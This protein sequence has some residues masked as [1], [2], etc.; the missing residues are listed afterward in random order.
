MARPTPASGTSCL[1]RNFHTHCSAATCPL[2]PAKFEPGLNHTLAEHRARATETGC[3]T[4]ATIVAGLTLPQNIVTWHESDPKRQGDSRGGSVPLADQEQPGDADRLRVE[5]M[6]DD[7]RDVVRTLLSDS[8]QNWRHFNFFRDPALA[9]TN[10][11]CQAFRPISHVPVDRTDSAQSLWHLKLWIKDCDRD[12]GCLPE[13]VPELPKRVLKVSDD[14]VVLVEPNG[15]RAHYMT[16]SHRWGEKEL[17][18][19]SKNSI[20]RLSNNIPWAD[21]PETYRQAISITRHLGIS[22]IWIDSVCI[23]QDSASDWRRESLRMRDIY[24]RSYL[25]IAASDA[26]SS[27]ESFTGP[28]HSAWRYPSSPIPGHREVL[29]QR[30]PFME[31]GDF[32]S[33]Y[34]TTPESPILLQRAWV[35]QERLLPSRIVYFDN[36]ELKWECRSVSDCQCGGMNVITRFRQDFNATLKG[37]GLPL[38]FAWMRISER[39]STLNLT[40]DRDRLIALSGVALQALQTG[41]GGRYLAGLWENDLAY[42]LCWYLRGNRRRPI[43]SP[44]PSLTTPI[45]PTS[46]ASPLSAFSPISP[47]GGNN[48]SGGGEGGMYIAPSWSW[49]SIFGSVVYD[50][51]MDYHKQASRLD[52]RIK[53]SKIILL[54]AEDPTGPVTGG[55]IK[56]DARAVELDVELLDNQRLWDQNIC[57]TYR[58]KHPSPS[59]EAQKLPIFQV[60]Y[61][62]PKEAARSIRSVLIVYWGHMWSMNNTFMVLKKTAAAPQQGIEVKKQEGNLF[63]RIGLIRSPSEKDKKM[64]EEL[65]ALC[66]P[67]YDIVVV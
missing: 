29:V 7:R 51:R 28:V 3:Q 38:P 41:L 11:S 37:M 26:S 63:E 65:L 40:K 5:L 27:S 58:L 31:H 17:F 62:L 25:N 13:G 60:D 43:F 18:I 64:G 47:G 19:L 33:N 48:G 32:G 66:Q 42:Q 8:S 10:S 9:Y 50:N 30:Q 45:S 12:H 57:R 14:K 23:I 36:R 53:E 6:S 56:L 46:P 22:Y 55:Y 2:K 1:C 61:I 16:L 35:L 34:Y 20:L 52:V 49:A 67:T 21:I 24:G 15:E 44:A 4:C 59:Q 39:Y 54:Q